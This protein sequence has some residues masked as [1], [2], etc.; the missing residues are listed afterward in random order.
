MAKKK[1]KASKS[2]RPRSSLQTK[3][4]DNFFLFG[5]RG[6]APTRFLEN[7][8]KRPFHADGVKIGLSP[9]A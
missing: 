3:D 8:A 2:S 1:T 4:S 9:A 5:I 6:F 7:L